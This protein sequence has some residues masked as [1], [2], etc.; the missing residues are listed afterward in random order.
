[1]V[2]G[3]ELDPVGAPVVMP[4]VIPDVIVDELPDP[5]GPTLGV[6][7]EDGLPDEIGLV[8]ERPTLKVDVAEV[9]MPVLEV[10]CGCDEPDGVP[11]LVCLPVELGT[12]L[13]PEW[14]VEPVG[15]PELWVVVT[16]VLEPVVVVE[17]AFVVTA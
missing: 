8:D 5:V 9:G 16:A 4:E 6:D 17:V 15:L 13:E 14:L 11:E 2:S 10:V 7:L 3:A 1:M 12:V